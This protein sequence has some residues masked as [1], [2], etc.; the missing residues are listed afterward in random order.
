M[1]G[2]SSV[3]TAA[4]AAAMAGVSA[5]IHLDPSLCAAPKIADMY[6]LSTASLGQGAFSEVFA[7]TRKGTGE[8]RAVKRVVKKLMKDTTEG[9][10]MEIELQRTCGANCD[11]I[12][13]IYDV[14]DSPM[15][16]D[17]VLEVMMKED[18]F[19]AI[20]RAC[21]HAVPHPPARPPSSP[22]GGVWG[23]LLRPRCTH[24]YW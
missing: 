2:R 12:V 24:E 8:K 9:V 10:E 6:Q 11:A 15:T 21:V 22:L 19:D 4:A 14:F 18:L 5:A 23:A 17:I 16:V 1:Q 7:C 13:K 20:E 3:C